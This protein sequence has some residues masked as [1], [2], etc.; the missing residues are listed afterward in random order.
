VAYRIVQEP[1]ADQASTVQAGAPIAV[2]VLA[3]LALAAATAM[4]S[5]EAGNAFR[6][7]PSREEP[8]PGDEVER[9]A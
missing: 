3:V 6:E 8:Q 2:A 4:R 5:E 9:P 7:V 1:G